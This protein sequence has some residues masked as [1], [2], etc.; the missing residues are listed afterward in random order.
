MN[1]F[2]GEHSLGYIIKLAL[3]S[4]SN[5]TK[6][7]ADE[8]SSF[9]KLAMN[10]LPGFIFGGLSALFIPALAEPQLKQTEEVPSAPIIVNTLVSNGQITAHVIHKMRLKNYGI[11]R[12]HVDKVIVAPEGLY[13]APV[14]YKVLH[15]DKTE[16]GWLEEKELRTEFI[17]QINEFNEPQKSVAYKAYFY[18]SAGNEIAAE[19]GLFMIRRGDIQKGN[20]DIFLPRLTMPETGVQS[21]KPSSP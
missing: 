2:L 1:A 20:A 7:P 8:K 18:G 21:I 9:L 6:N 14:G 19:G 10:Q 17:I 16:I 4:M 3:K 12:A 15:F 11:R 5:K 13:E